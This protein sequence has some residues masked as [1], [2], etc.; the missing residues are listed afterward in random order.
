MRRRR[1]HYKAGFDR[2][3]REKNK[4]ISAGEW[5]FLRKEVQET[6]V[7]PKLA[8]PV[9]GPYR[10]V[11][12]DGQTFSLRIGDEDVRVSSDRITPAPTPLGETTTKEVIPH[13]GQGES[14]DESGSRKTQPMERETQQQGMRCQKRLIRRR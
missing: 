10:V 11:H 3:V 4:E 6:G 14:D 7:S 2:S 13:R 8:S 5:I 1:P 9:E 12:T